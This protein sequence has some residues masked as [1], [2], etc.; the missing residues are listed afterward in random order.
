MVVKKLKS[1]QGFIMKLNSSFLK[2]FYLDFKET[3]LEDKSNT[4]DFI[5]KKITEVDEIRNKLFTEH[6]V[7]AFMNE[8]SF[9]DNQL[10]AK[11]FK[12]IKVDQNFSGRVTTA[13]NKIFDRDK[14]NQLNISKLESK[15]FNNYLS[16]NLSSEKRK[17]S[18]KSQLELTKYKQKL[19]DFNYPFQVKLFL[20][21]TILTLI[22]LLL[23]G[24]IEFYLTLKI[25]QN[26]LDFFKMWSSNNSKNIYFSSVLLLFQSLVLID[27]DLYSKNFIP[28]VSSYRSLII[29]KIKLDINKTIEFNN[30]LTDYFNNLDPDLQLLFNNRS[31]ITYNLLN[32]L[33]VI[34]EYESLGSLSNLIL[35][36]ISTI[37]KNNLKL[38]NQMEIFYRSKYLNNTSV[39]DLI[40]EIFYII[41]NSNQVLRFYYEVV[42]KRIDTIISTQSSYL[43]TNYRD[44][45]TYLS[46]GICSVALII[47]YILISNIM[48]YKLKVL[49]IFFLIERKWADIII[50][51]CRKYLEESQS[52][53]KKDNN[54][55]KLKSFFEES[56]MESKDSKNTVDNQLSQR[57]AIQS[58][59]T[60]KILNN[61][62]SDNNTKN[63]L[64]DSRG[65]SFR[66][67]NEKKENFLIYSLNLKEKDKFQG[68]EEEDKK[69]NPISKK[70]IETDLV[71]IQS[72][73]SDLHRNRWF[74]YTQIIFPLLIV[75]IYFIITIILNNNFNSDISNN[76]IYLSYIG[77]R[78]WSFNN[79]LIFYR[80]MMM[81]GFKYSSIKNLNLSSLYIN[82]DLD[83]IDCFNL[84]YNKSSLNENMIKIISSL[85]SD[86]LN[87]FIVREN[88]FATTDFC[89]NLKN[90]D[91]NFY[92]IYQKNCITNLN[93]N[94]LANSIGLISNFLYN[95]YYSLKGDNDT[96]ISLNLTTM[97]DYVSNNNLA[98]YLDNSLYYIDQAFICELINE[99][100]G[101]SEYILSNQFYVVTRN[102]IYLFILLLELIFF[103]IFANSL[104]NKINKDKSILSV[105]PSKAIM[106]NPKMKN[107]LENLKNLS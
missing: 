83:S 51:R 15:E 62:N 18:F 92:D 107:A 37:I 35:I 70:D 65:K 78:G 66:R 21:L 50:K 61:N 57:Y 88:S 31:I 14:D 20:F 17:K 73:I 22:I 93:K 85:R 39:S 19:F 81:T 56:K 102:S 45:V 38:D 2:N 97:I 89:L 30:N 49:I 82:T 46:F 10:Y 11:I 24:E 67:K 64:I 3:L 54:K 44:Y 69:D 84:Y 42:E 63:N 90:F 55:K 95:N 40:R 60:E 6:N 96:I 23:I 77:S 12:I 74:K 1:D 103:I 86:L 80:N 48:N 5:L 9:N 76:S 7:V 100:A 27:N 4:F 52:F 59:E 8:I 99:F 28:D 43:I 91:S 72:S 26:L 41:E 13:F 94:G 98:I 58:N 53:L 32:N 25:D 101:I 33:T 87:N 106:N 29:S 71:T 34:N 16:K 104:K 47:F 36:K 79:L 105:I 75:C 68:Q